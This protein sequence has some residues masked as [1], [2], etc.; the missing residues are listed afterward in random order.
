V[1]LKCSRLHFLVQKDL[2][3]FA[4][5]KLKE[6]RKKDIREVSRAKKKKKHTETTSIN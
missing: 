3:T 5:G 6:N 2:S 4:G 1:S